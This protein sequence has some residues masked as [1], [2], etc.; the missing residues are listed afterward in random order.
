MSYWWYVLFLFAASTL[1]LILRQSRHWHIGCGM[2]IT[3][4]HNGTVHISSRLLNSPAGRA[5]IPNGA[6]LL[7]Y[8]GTPLSGLGRNAWKETMQRLRP[9]RVGDIVRCKIRTTNG[10]T[11]IEMKAARVWTSIPDYSDRRIISEDER[12]HFKEGVVYCA[13]TGQW[14]PYVRLSDHALRSIFNYQR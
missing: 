4:Y 9:R 1:M 14:F 13:K 6:E 2:N 8:N 10:E 12:E 7:E 11:S 3:R 5:G